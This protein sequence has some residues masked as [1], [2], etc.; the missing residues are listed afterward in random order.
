MKRFGLLFILALILTGCSDPM[1]GEPR[2]AGDYIGLVL[3]WLIV[4]GIAAIWT[5]LS[6][7][8]KVHTPEEVRRAQNDPDGLPPRKSKVVPVG[9]Q[10]RFWLGVA[11]VILLALAFL[12]G[13][14]F[15]RL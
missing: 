8:T 13:K 7:H 1:T 9:G 12:L 2:G 6:G 14:W 4:G 3:F 10:E 5:C 15:F 11:G